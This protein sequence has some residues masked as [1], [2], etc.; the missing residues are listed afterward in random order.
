MSAQIFTMLSSELDWP[1]WKESLRQHLTEIDQYAWDL[2]TGVAVQPQPMGP[3]PTTEEAAALTAANNNVPPTGST[4][5]D[6]MTYYNYLTGNTLPN[7]MSYA[8]RLEVWRRANNLGLQ[9]IRTSIS[10]IPRGIIAGMNRS[11]QV[12]VQLQEVYGTP[13]PDY[14]LV[15]SMYYDWS[16]MRFTD[17]EDPA[18]FVHCFREAL[19]NIRS[20]SYLIHPTTEWGVFNSATADS[21]IGRGFFAI[22]RVH[23]IGEEGWMEKLYVDFVEHAVDNQDQAL[24]EETSDHSSEDETRVSSEST[25]AGDEAAIAESAQDNE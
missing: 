12:F 19:A 11:R 13:R 18:V 6:L 4:N 17:D 22:H 14:D 8:T 1:A 20:H 7:P 15:K 2:I 16:Q 24:Y 21:R 9:V 25:A 10:S 5:E 23:N 3:V